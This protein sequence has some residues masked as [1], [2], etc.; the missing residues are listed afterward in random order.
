MYDRLYSFFLLST[1]S[2]I[3]FNLGFE[4]IWLLHV[5]L[6]NHTLLWKKVNMPTVFLLIFEKPLT[7]LPVAKQLARGCLLLE[8]KYVAFSF[9]AEDNQDAMYS[10]FIEYELHADCLGK[11]SSDHIYIYIILYQIR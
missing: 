9:R 1:V 11:T 6:I 8:E 10:L 2:C 5:C 4:L 7:Q 3:H